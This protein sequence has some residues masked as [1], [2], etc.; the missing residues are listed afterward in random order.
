MLTWGCGEGIEEVS[1]HRDLGSAIVSTVCFNACIQI[2]ASASLHNVHTNKT[3]Q[4]KVQ[5]KLMQEGK[6]K[7]KDK[8]LQYLDEEE[9]GLS[10][11]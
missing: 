4:S 2:S 1:F 10:H 8:L 5:G 6:E 9:F 3:R 11:Q 7:K